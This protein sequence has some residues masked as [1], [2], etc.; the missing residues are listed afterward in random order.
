MNVTGILCWKCAI[1]LPP[2][3]HIAVKIRILEIIKLACPLNWCFQYNTTSIFPVKVQHWIT[4]TSKS[5]T[6]SLMFFGTERFAVADYVLYFWT[7]ITYCH[8]DCVSIEIQVFTSI[9]GPF[10]QAK[11]CCVHTIFRLCTFMS[12]HVIYFSHL[13]LFR[14]ISPILLPILRSQSYQYRFCRS[15]VS[16]T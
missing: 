7:A 3:S 9:C 6:P 4:F 5:S 2:T 14:H 8:T 10:I 1:F 16:C 12:L 13:A 11:T 15:N